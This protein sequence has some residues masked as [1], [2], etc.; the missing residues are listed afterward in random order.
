MDP[1]KELASDAVLAASSTASSGLAGVWL[2][3]PLELAPA[4]VLELELQPVTAAAKST[5]SPAAHHGN[6]VTL[7]C[8]KTSE[9][10]P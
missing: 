2:A 9:A 1:V 3:D 6:R 4:E 10:R 7:C 5:T 8:I